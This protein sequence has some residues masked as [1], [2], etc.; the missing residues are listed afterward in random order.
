MV[1]PTKLLFIEPSDRPSA[2]PVIDELTCKMAAALREA[3]R[4]NPT[5][6]W[7]T[8]YCRATSDNCEHLLPNGLITNSLSVHY[9]AHHRNEISREELGKVAQL[10]YGEAWPT[11]QE[12]Y[13]G[14]HR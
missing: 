8:C 10:E 9:L 14:F 2:K 3:E 7:H 12:L 5:R 6:G 4:I 11:D 1:D 13:P